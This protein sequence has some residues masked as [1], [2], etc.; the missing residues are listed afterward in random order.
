MRFPVKPGM[1][2][3]LELESTLDEENPSF[4]VVAEVELL[5]SPLHA[6]NKVTE[7]NNA[8]KYFKEYLLIFQNSMK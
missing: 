5:E 1:T 7:N 4:G 6:I 2:E 3:E 8:A